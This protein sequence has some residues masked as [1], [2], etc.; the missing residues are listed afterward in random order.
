MTPWD[1]FCA[2]MPPPVDEPEGLEEPSKAPKEG[3]VAWEDNGGLQRN[4]RLSN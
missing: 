3:E 2:V 1:R 4:L